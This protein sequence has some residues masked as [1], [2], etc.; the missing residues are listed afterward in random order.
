LIRARRSPLRLVGVGGISTAEHVGEFLRG[1]AHAVQLATAAMRDPEV[2][3]AIRRT[4]LG[5]T[6]TV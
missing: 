3:L 6:R 1:G 4:H 5:T 2:G